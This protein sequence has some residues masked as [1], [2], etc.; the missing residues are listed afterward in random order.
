MSTENPR[1]LLKKD[2]EQNHRRGME[3]MVEHTGHEK[4]SICYISLFRAEILRYVGFLR[5]R[6][7]KK[8]K[9]VETVMDFS[10]D[11]E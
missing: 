3:R 6:K 7:N 5:N 9:Y 2:R 8:M 10:A 4:R 1:I 11:Q